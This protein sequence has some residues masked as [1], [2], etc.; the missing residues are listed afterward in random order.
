MPFVTL[1]TDFGDKGF[2]LPKLKG[3][4]LTAAASVQLIDLTHQVG[5]YNIVQAAFLFRNA[6][7]SFPKGTIHLISVN[8]YPSNTPRFLAAAH[9]G[10]YFIA[11][12]NGL[13]SLIFPEDAP[14]QY[15]L[16][17]YG[18]E[19]LISLEQ[20]YARAV[21]HL[22]QGRPIIELGET[23]TEVMQ[24]IT[25]QPV[26]GPSQIR[27]SVIFVDSF[28]NAITN[29][30]RA[31]FEQVGGGRSFALYFKRNDPIKNLCQYYHE[32]DIGEPL[33]LFN[34]SN[35][36]EIAINMGKASSLLGIHVEDTV[37]I[38]FRS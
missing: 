24:R 37:Q 20:V 13:F 25:L 28:D 21:G 33:C 34:S 30:N 29:I 12:D 8:D 14:N 18:P 15:H 19:E 1:T 32:V 35:L 4:L 11:P 23:A 36:L 26:I 38:E 22:A 5:N 3:A 2:D 31:L 10:H 16:I 27:G 17:S 6:W 9:R 7:P